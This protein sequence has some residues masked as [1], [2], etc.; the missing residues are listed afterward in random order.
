MGIVLAMWL[1]RLE[2][3]LLGKLVMIG[4]WLLSVLLPGQSTTSGLRSAG[5]L[6]EAEHRRH[7]GHTT[8]GLWW[9]APRAAVIGW[10]IATTAAAAH[11]VRDRP[12]TG[13]TTVAERHTA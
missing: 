1:A 9:F 6:D 2:A 7:A 12:V 4:E 13:H 11:R 3:A 8:P 5:E 10:L